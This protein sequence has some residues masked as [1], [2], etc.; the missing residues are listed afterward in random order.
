[1][2]KLPGVLLFLILVIFLLE[3]FTLRTL[4]NAEKRIGVLEKKIA[5][6]AV[7]TTPAAGT[8]AEVK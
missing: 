5:A 1:M 8:P 2:T 3:I 7:V 6:Q 4:S